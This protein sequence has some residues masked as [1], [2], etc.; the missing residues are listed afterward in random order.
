MHELTDC[1]NN[2]GLVNRKAFAHGPNLF[3]TQSIIDHLIGD[4]VEVT[5]PPQQIDGIYFK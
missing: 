1:I 2:K 5:Y 3:S 4:W